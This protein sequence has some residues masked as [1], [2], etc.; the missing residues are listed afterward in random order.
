MADRAGFEPAIPLQVYTLSKRAPSAARP[1]VPQ[2]AATI[3]AKETRTSQASPRWSGARG[4]GPGFTLSYAFCGLAAGGPAPQY[5]PST[6]CPLHQHTNREDHL[7]A[8]SLHPTLD[9]P[10]APAAP[11]FSGGTLVCKC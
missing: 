11:G 7:M 1:P 4:L 3:A 6:F 8:L 10:I 5:R 9:R 2:A